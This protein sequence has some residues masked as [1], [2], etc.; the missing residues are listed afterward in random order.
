[1][2]NIIGGGNPR[3]RHGLPDDLEVPGDM[4]FDAQ[5]QEVEGRFDT[6]DQAFDRAKDSLKRMNTLIDEI[7][8]LLDHGPNFHPEVITDGS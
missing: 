8:E 6:M 4:P 3:F 1:M 5:V 7:Q 2:G